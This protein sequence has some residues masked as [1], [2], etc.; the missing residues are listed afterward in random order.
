MY[1]NRNAISTTWKDLG[2]G[3]D[4]N[5]LDIGVP[6]KIPKKAIPASMQITEGLHCTPYR[7]KCSRGYSEQN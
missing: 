4:S 3:I 6:D 5:R 1:H 2:G 7:G